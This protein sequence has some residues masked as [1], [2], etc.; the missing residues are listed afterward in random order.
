MNEQ[1][2]QPL[3]VIYNGS[4][5]ICSR[6]V[7]GYA[8]YAANND[9]DL[10]FEDLND[11]DLNAYGLDRD[12]AAKQFH[13]DD[14]HKIV[15]GVDAFILLWSRMPRFRFLARFVS[16]PVIKPI[17]RVVYDRVLAP[18]LFAM[19]KRRERRKNA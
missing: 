15:G 4:C 12:T 1:T 14:G 19:H 17:A 11:V 10:K 16:L 9:L 3:K 8:K 18:A 2:D 13:V 5:P 7:N 6:E